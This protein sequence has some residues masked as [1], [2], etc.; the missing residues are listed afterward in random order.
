[1]GP[2]CFSKSLILKE[3]RAPRA[4]GSTLL[5]TMSLSNGRGAHPFLL[6]YFAIFLDKRQYFAYA[7][8]IM[9]IL[10]IETSCDDTCVAIVEATPK[11][12]SKIPFFK[13]L[14]NIVS[15]QTK[16][17]AKYG[18][19]VPS[20]A[21]REHQRNLVPVLKKA[22]RE[23]RFRNSKFEIRNS[24]QIK[25]TKLEMLEKILKREPML[26][27]DFLKNIAQIKKPKID[28][29]A[30]T[31]GPGLEPALWAG[32]N[33]ARA[34]S[35]YWDIPLLG[36]DHMRGHIAA[37]FI[38]QQNIGTKSVVSGQLSDRKSVV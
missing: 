26:L 29:I 32:V 25:N 11:A 1:M 12:G 14:S 33:F 3:T 31:N 4:C 18:G 22:L 34:L 16:I 37:N 28:L 23:T 36:V 30:V 35:F 17:H 5:T 24:K 27:H 20:L 2:P 7:I 15:S 10:A 8:C 21:K 6:N 13:I 19:V 38:S 9:R